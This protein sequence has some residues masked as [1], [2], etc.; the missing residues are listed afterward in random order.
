MSCIFNLFRK[1]KAKKTDEH[2]DLRISNPLNL[3]E[4]PDTLDGLRAM[5]GALLDIIVSLHYETETIKANIRTSL[6]SS[7]RESI[8]K[9]LAKGNVLAEKKKKYSVRLRR[10]QE[11][12]RELHQEQ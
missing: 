8:H 9:L 4:L 6:Q 7:R 11:K 3:D 12:I 5:E 10:V 2:L 1:N